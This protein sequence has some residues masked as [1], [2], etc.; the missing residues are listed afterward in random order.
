[1]VVF[2]AKP[3]SVV[4]NEY[5]E[6][7][8]TLDIQERLWGLTNERLVTV[9]FSEGYDDSGGLDVRMR[10]VRLSPRG[11]GETDCRAIRTDW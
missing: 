2:V 4:K 9:H 8:V 5:H 11:N 3:V 1:M 6:A 10:N 7:T